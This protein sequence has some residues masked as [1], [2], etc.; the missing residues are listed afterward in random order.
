MIT[1]LPSTALVAIA[2]AI[3]IACTPRKEAAAVPAP[4]DVQEEQPAL[5]PDVFYTGKVST[6]FAGES[7]PLLVQVN[8]QDGVFLIPIGLSTQ[9]ATDGLQIRFRYRLSRANNGGCMKG[10]TAILEDVGIA[11]KSDGSNKMRVDQ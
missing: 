6:A 2:C 5:T 9:F 4:A 10:Q 8:E 3:A 1:R 11:R 7:C